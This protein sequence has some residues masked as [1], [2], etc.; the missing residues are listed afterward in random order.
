MFCQLYEQARGMVI[1]IKNSFLC[2][3]QKSFRLKGTVIPD[4][5]HD[6]IHKPK[7]SGG[8]CRI[9]GYMEVRTCLPTKEPVSVSLPL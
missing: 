4:V 7:L 6:I 5:S 3:L 8:T 2:D 9:V 1:Y